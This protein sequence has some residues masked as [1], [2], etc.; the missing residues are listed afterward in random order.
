M[1]VIRTLDVS[2]YMSNLKFNLLKYNC[3]LQFKMLIKQKMKIYVFT[4][5]K[6][7]QCFLKFK[8]VSEICSYIFEVVYVIEITECNQRSIFEILSFTKTQC[9]KLH[10][11][12][13]SFLKSIYK[14]VYD[15]ALILSDFR[16]ELYIVFKFLA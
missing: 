15:Y 9:L 8:N 3:I 14:N 11:M 13:Q 7:I 6:K 10:L 12:C 16:F 1:S 4:L 5:N 2:K